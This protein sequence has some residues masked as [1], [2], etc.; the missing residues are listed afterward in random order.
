MR[1]LWVDK[2]HWFRRDE[3]GSWV[4]RAAMS[5]MPHATNATYGIR[6]NAENPIERGRGPKVRGLEVL[7]AGSLI[8]AIA[9]EF[10]K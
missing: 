1:H 6:N 2:T 9:D 3:A 8:L 7:I 10:K 4:E 5:K